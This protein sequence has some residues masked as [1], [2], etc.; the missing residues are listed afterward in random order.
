MC[1]SVFVIPTA[2]TSATT[3]QDTDEIS[4]FTPSLTIPQ[5]L[6]YLF[7]YFEP[8]R[9]I[10]LSYNRTRSRPNLLLSPSRETHTPPTPNLRSTL[11][12]VLG[13]ECVR[14]YI[15]HTSLANGPHPIGSIHGYNCN[16]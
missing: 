13:C 15:P 9:S 2:T 4:A 11:P 10:H 14:V 8:T 7:N 5:I 12:R 6:I 1:S 3:T 16:P